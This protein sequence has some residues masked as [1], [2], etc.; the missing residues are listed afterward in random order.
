MRLICSNICQLRYTLLTQ[1]L[2]F[3][4]QLLR[5]G[6]VTDRKLVTGPIDNCCRQDWSTSGFLG[7]QR[8]RKTNLYG[9]LEPRMQPF[10][11]SVTI[12]TLG[13]ASNRVVVFVKSTAPTSR[14]CIIVF[15]LW[16]F[17]FFHCN[18]IHSILI[19]YSCLFWV[20]N[21]GL[22]SCMWL[23]S[24]HHSPLQTVW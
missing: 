19:L 18:I 16:L 6:K 24:N 8:Y 17:Y 12:P 21:Y 11:E 3:M 2:Q 4:E 23:H 15:F 13:H 9:D 20:K 5:D 22:S 14:K 1:V 7:I 10:S